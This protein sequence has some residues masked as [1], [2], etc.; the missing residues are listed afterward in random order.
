VFYVSVP[1]RRG[2]GRECRSTESQA[3]SVQ[4]SA[5]Y[6]ISGHD[7]TPIGLDA[8]LRANVLGG[9]PES[10]GARSAGTL[11]GA[12]ESVGETLKARRLGLLA[13]VA[14]SSSLCEALRQTPAP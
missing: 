10:I 8:A 12:S 5:V 6:R 7:Q 9:S 13:L 2:W 4:A 3:V 1:G 11:A 14:V